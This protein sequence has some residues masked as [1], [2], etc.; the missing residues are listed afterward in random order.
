M[1]P[2]EAALAALSLQ[3][4]PNYT[5]TA[6]EYGVERSTLSRRHR[7]ITGP[8]AEG[9]YSQ[10]FLTKQ[11]SEALVTYI[12]KLMNCG[13]SPTVAMVRSFGQEITGITLGIH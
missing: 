11:Q 1:D 2:I 4:K 12:N 8:K 13:L 9:Y 3:S 7:N 10:S 6:K 5:Q